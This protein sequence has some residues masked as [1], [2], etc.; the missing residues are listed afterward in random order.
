[1]FFRVHPWLKL[2]LLSSGILILVNQ[3][4]GNP[5]GCPTKRANWSSISAIF[6]DVG[7]HYRIRSLKIYFR[8]SVSR[9]KPTAFFVGGL[10]T[11]A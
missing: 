2:E 3:F 9:S 11:I 4:M 10:S 8:F 1:V 6:R 7:V 5:E